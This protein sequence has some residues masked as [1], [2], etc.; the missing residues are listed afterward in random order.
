MFSEWICK[1]TVSSITAMTITPKI[2]EKIDNY[3]TSIL[4][5]IDFLSKGVFE[6]AGVR[7]R[8]SV[9]AFM[10]VIVYENWGDNKGHRYLIGEE[11]KYGN[12]L[13]PKSIPL[14]SSILD[15]CYYDK[16]WIDN[17]T[18]SLLDNIRLKSNDKAHD[19]NEPIKHAVLKT[20]LE[21]CMDLSQQLTKLFYSHLGQAIP[22]EISQAYIDGFVDTKTIHDLQESDIVSFIENVDSFEKSSRYILVA[23]FSMRDISESL[24]RNLMGVRWSMVIDFDCH[25]KED[26]GLYHSMMPE[27]EDNCT[28]FT[29]LNK[30]D[31][32]N[33]SKGT[34]G[35]INWIYANGL[36]TINGTVTP[37]IK[38]WIGKRMHRFIKDVLTE[39][40]KKSLSRIHIISLLE[41]EEYLEEIIRQFD[42]IDFAERDLVSFNI[43]SENQT[44]RDNMS[45]LSRYGFDILCYSFSTIRFLSEIGDFL[46]PDER[47]SVLVP[48]RNAQNENVLLDITDIYSKLS[49]NGISVVHLDIVSEV[50]TAIEELPAFYRGETITWK[51]LESDVD[52][53]RS[54]YDELQ[55]KILER[56]NSR[57]SQKFTLYHYA[58][59]GGTTIS[60][61]LAYNLREQV[62]TILINKYIKGVTFDLIELLSIKVNRP[63]LTIVESSKVGNIDELIADCNAKKRVVVFVYVDRILRKP[64][65]IGQPHIEI[66]NDHMHD[67]EEKTKFA[68]KVQLYH[69]NSSSKEWIKKT[70]FSNCEV[71]DFSMSIAENNYEKNSLRG[72]IQQYLKQ[73]SEPVA[74][75]LVYVAMI[76]H[77]AQITVSD[78]VFRKLFVTTTGK[79][80]LSAYMRQHP[81]EMTF[82]KKL[83]T[84]DEATYS[85]ERLWR[86][87]YSLFAD[88]ILEELLGG[89]YPDRW[90][91]AI[92]EWSRKLIRTVKDNYEFLTDDVQR[93]LVAV[94]LE[95]EKED[96][97]GQEETWGARGAQEKFSQL[98]DDMSYSMD[99]Q[100]AILKLLAESYPSVPH[101]WGHLARFCYENADTPDQFAEAVSYINRALDNGGKGDYNLL[102]IAGMCR[103]RL[104]EYYLRNHIEIEREELK[105][106][107]ELARDYFRL[108]REVNPRN[109]HAYT[110]EIQLLSLVIEYGKTFSKH[111]NYNAFL[112]ESK[113]TWFFELYEDMNDLIDELTM[114]LNQIET[115]GI[116][117]RFNRSKAMLAKSES[118]LWEYMGDY[119]ESLRTLQE[120]IRTADRLALPS[121][122]IMYVRTLL[123]SKVNGSRDKIME[124]WEKLDEKELELV[125]NYLNKNV[126]QDSSNLSSMRLWIQFVRYSGVGISIEEVKSRLKMMFKS[127][128]DYP[129]TKLEAAYNLYILNLFEL[130]R[131]N[132]TLNGRKREEI[133]KW[134]NVCV[135]LSSS[136][137]YPFEWLANLDG[138]HGIVNSKDKS[139]FDQLARISGVITEIKSNRQGKIRLDCGYDVFFTPYVGNFIQGKDET[140]CVDMVLGFRHEGPAAYEVARLVKKKE[141]FSEALIEEV[142]E[143]LA[144]TEVEAVE[145]VF[146]EPTKAT[147]MITDV[148]TKVE[149]PQIKILGKIDLDQFEKYKRPKNLKKE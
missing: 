129:M 79:N 36:S 39:F 114:L 50:D 66:I 87:R 43:I 14:F 72:Y 61:R 8:K 103:R 37:D 78:L 85:E 65:V 49:S 131:D 107:T 83:I 6:E 141:E 133:Q 123:L 18:H 33:M 119:K 132:D 94:F 57:Q 134:V 69:P 34:N 102:H 149:G 67:A 139:K 30:D 16:H 95:R 106:A 117:V 11:D 144:I 46:S 136:D 74:E 42:G 32:L 17:K 76:Y 9:E 128:N 130:I 101:F 96:L 112:I 25:S 29:I 98:M 120:H 109:V 88:V 55:R 70:P 84:D 63:I 5:A 35:N 1:H 13:N 81:Q 73:L 51:E 21:E 148:K 80:G 19:P 127:S 135:N 91:D 93:V 140:T 7:F 137:K 145:P 38:A 122:R 68:Y 108:S 77:Y 54:K 31:L 52:V 62:P 99:D 82:L 59:A 58:G 147:S 124:A 3:R 53:Q 23:P 41:E 105:E 71:I 44:I 138:I 89:E 115:L 56:L 12:L 100:K 48:G 121:L 110:S 26:G 92:P 28:P 10:K 125:E 142:T 40:C 126:Q 116:T 90:K 27:I 15:L 111:N 22:N 60:R 2:Q 86:P 143:E 45:K 64:S 47:H 24:I 146:K 20:Q 104:I 118:K 4:M 97:L 75:F 113:N